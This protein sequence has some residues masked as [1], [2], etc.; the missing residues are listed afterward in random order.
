MELPSLD[1]LNNKIKAQQPK[2]IT[3]LERSDSGRAMRYGVDLLS[4]V[5]V[6]FVA[7]FYLDRWLETKPIFMLI[8]IILGMGAG[9]LNVFRANQR[10]IAELEA[11]EEKVH[12][13]KEKLDNQTKK[14]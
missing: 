1:E 7:G 12:F 3:A 9:F 2:K 11:D 13:V 5:A 6:G 4:G 10:Y 14:Q 8:G